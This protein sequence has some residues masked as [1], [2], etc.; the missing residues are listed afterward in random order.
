MVE[1]IEFIISTTTRKIRS[2]EKNGNNYY[3]LS[4]QKFKKLID[5]NEL[6]E[7]SIVHN[8]YYGVTKKEF[9]RIH[10]IDRIPIFDV[11]VQGAIK[12]KSVLKRPV[13][14]FIIPPSYKELKE[15]LIKRGTDR[16]EDINLRLKNA[17]KELKE[18]DVF[19]YII[20][21]DVIENAIDDIKSIIRAELCKNKAKA[22]NLA[23]TLSEK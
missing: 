12:L 17:K 13:L 4:E 16:Q 9:D 8:N 3:F 14:I 2:G 11:D 15:R 6:L 10:S 22:Y 7:W 1:G 21:N 5:N 19:D 20:I 18:V 23:R